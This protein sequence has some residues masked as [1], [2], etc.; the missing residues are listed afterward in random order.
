MAW[1]ETNPLSERKRF[2]EAYL[3]GRYDVTR[4]CEVFGISRKTAYKFV[5][6]FREGGWDALSDRSHEAHCHPNETEPSIVELIIAAKMERPRW[7]PGKLLDALHREQPEVAWPAV[8]TAGEILNRRGLVKKRAKHRTSDHPGK[9]KIPAVVRANQLQ[10]IDFK[11]QMR[12]LDGRLCYPLT[13]T[14]TFSRAL[15]LCQGF[16]EPTFANTRRALERCFREYGLPEAI[17]SDNGTP[18]VASHALGGLSRLSVWLMKIG[19]ERIRTRPG[20][21]QDNGLHERMHR[22]LK[23]ET[24]FPPAKHMAAQQRR[25]DLFRVD[26]NDK[27]PHA[28]IGGAVPSSLYSRSSRPYPERVPSI[29]YPAHYETRA[30][31]TDG[32]IKWKGTCLFLSEALVDERVGLEET[33]YGIWSIYFG[34]TLLALLDERE[35]IIKA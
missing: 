5:A 6:R 24:A 20:C 17:R 4:L 31:R 11:G 16:A 9:P 25:F 21:P 35:G 14:D 26:F 1:K 2:I 8:S 19:I 18:F 10:N 12:T 13:L 27:R 7:G 22:T 32:R 29:E 34:S 15:L 28:G 30:V 33:G 3:K 23:E